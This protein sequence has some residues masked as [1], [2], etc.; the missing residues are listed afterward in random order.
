MQIEAKKNTA[1]YLCWPMVDSTTPAS[2]KSGLTVTVAA[3]YKD[4]IG[5]WTAFTPV[6]TPAE[7]GTTGIYEMDLSA[8]EMNHDKV[9]LKFS[10]SGA[11]DTA[12]L[13]DL[14]TKLVD[15][16]NDL[17]QS[18]ILSDATPFAG[19]NID[20]AISS[21]SSHSAA[22]VWTVATRTLTASLD[23]TAAEIADAVWDE[24]RADHVATGTMGE[25]VKWLAEMT[26]DDLGVRRYTANALEQA[27]TGGGGDATLA[28]Q[29]IMKDWLQALMSKTYTLQ[30]AV[31]TYDPATDSNE[32]IRDNQAGADVAA[33]ADA[34]LDELLSEHTTS[35]SLGKT[36]SD[37]ADGSTTLSVSIANAATSIPSVLDG[38]TISVRKAATLTLS[39]T[40]LGS[41]A[42]RSN[43]YFTGKISPAQPD[44]DSLFQVSESGGLL[45]IN[46][47]TP[48]SSSNGSITVDDEAAG[49]ITIT[50]KASEMAKLDVTSGHADIKLIKLDGT[51][52]VLQEYTLNITD[53]VTLKT[54]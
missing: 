49:D 37:M 38:G 30:N 4:G 9:L 46:G 51:V 43:I 31:G 23:P 52:S 15:D 16:L 32:A 28:N 19:A 25:L 47:G 21:R 7:I 45:V 22:D 41:L 24:A 3:Y 33:I 50:I 8:S 10:A 53:V 13:F 20:A 36:I 29:T 35:G 12:F 17:A 40:G 54:S 39:V 11:A 1:Y 42:S 5:A 18:D 34:V 48:D 44:A 2:Y 14:R 26:E 27:P 6:D